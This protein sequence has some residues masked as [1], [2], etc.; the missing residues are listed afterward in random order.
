MLGRRPL[1][2]LGCGAYLAFAFLQ[3]PASTAYR[4]FAPADVVLSGI[5]GTVWS[6]RAALGSVGG[7]ALR[8]LE[9]RVSPLPLLIG[10]LST[11]ASAQLPDGFVNASVSATM[12]TLRFTNLELAT[13]LET[14]AQ[15]LPLGGARGTLS[16]DLDELTLRDG[17]PVS[18]AG[19]VRLRRL[20][21]PPLVP[22]SGSSSV[23]LGDYELSSFELADLRL[24]AS[25][26]D[27]GGPL[28]VVGTVAVDLQAP[29]SLDGAAP[30]FDGRVR[31]RADVP[32]MLREPLEFLTVDV[33]AEGWRTL[34]LDP[35]LQQL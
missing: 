23:L 26:R 11:D 8:D 3:F 16:V 15:V 34:D 32:N 10:R 24:G 18:A 7:L 27:T 2:A 6:G 13:S 19:V 21:V 29:R 14:I 35:W 30:S 25:L 28:E 33:D 22:G 4:W 17:W 5:S 20:E 9:W 31:E 1:L 12:S